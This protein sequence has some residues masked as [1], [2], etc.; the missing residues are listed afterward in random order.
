MFSLSGVQEANA[1]GR[2]NI[3]LP[4]GSIRE[5]IRT[6]HIAFTLII[7][8]IKK[9]VIRIRTLVYIMTIIRVNNTYLVIGFV[10]SRTIYIYIYSFMYVRT[11]RTIRTTAILS[12]SLCSTSPAGAKN[13]VFEPFLQRS[14]YQDRLGTSPE[15]SR[16]RKKEKCFVR[17]VALNDTTPENGCPNFIPG[18]HRRMRQWQF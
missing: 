14:S 12:S 15:K 1:R 9:L 11:T 8:A 13:R 16:N 17:R 7:I 2:Q 3:P 6:G 10:G 18:L 4:P 5:I